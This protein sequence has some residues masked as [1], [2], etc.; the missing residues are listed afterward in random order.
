MNITNVALPWCGKYLPVKVDDE[1]SSFQYKNVRTYHSF[2]LPDAVV[3]SHYSGM[4]RGSGL[5]M[6]P[7]AMGSH[8]KQGCS[9]T[10]LIQG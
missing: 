6:G 2:D 7:G 8:I 3:H 5:E 10:G 4:V 1:V 9:Y